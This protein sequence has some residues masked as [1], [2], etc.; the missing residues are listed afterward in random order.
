MQ[1]S[2]FFIFL[3]LGC[4]TQHTESKYQ[5]LLAYEGR[6]EYIAETTLDIIASEIDTT[7][8][9][10][11]D[12]AKYPLNYIAQDSFLDAQGAPVV[13]QRDK[14]KNVISYTA[15]QQTFKLLTRDFERLQM[16]PRK[17]LLH[18]PNA[19]QY[20][21]PQ[22]KNDGLETGTI[23][24][25]VEHPEHIVDMVKATIQG[26]FPDVHSILIY[27]ND[28]LVLEEYFYNYDAA[29]PHQLR[30]ATK[31]IIGGILGIAIDKG[32]VQSEKDALLPYFE[33]SYP[34]IAHI[35]DKKK[36]ITIEDFLRYRH[37]MD[38]DNNNPK[39]KGNEHSMMESADWV[40]FTLDLPMIREPG[41]ASSY[42]TGCALTIGSL[43]EK[44]TQQNL[45][46]FAKKHLFTPM[47][48]SNYTWIFEPNKASMTNFSQLSIRPRDL[49]KL[50]KMYKDGGVWEGKQILSESWINKTFDMED[51][52][53]GYMWKHK[54]FTVDG[55]RYDSYMATGNGG[56][57]INIWPDLDMITVFTGGNYNSY[58][59]YGKST[60]PNEM[61]PKYILK[62]LD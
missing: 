44:A 57:K 50:A 17:A 27:K 7:L 26:D 32:F 60:P 45:E 34:N 12:K 56:Q 53:Y 39:S 41:T 5:K 43:I 14:D 9:A 15:E 48:I 58:A 23:A 8:Y 52:D 40:K 59:L 54:Y 25:V 3:F 13:F 46:N 20:R 51:G 2:L 1:K 36:K 19:Y 29:T 21:I 38:C 31:P 30:S 47:E 62:A 22:Q 61:I 11:L 55:Q 4:T 37:G 33:S 10:V 18:N 16:T 35:D 28:K 6:Y 42:C 49:V 24:D